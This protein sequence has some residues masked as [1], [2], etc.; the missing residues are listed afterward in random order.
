MILTGRE[1]GRALGPLSSN[2]PG[3][4]T[5]CGAK[6]AKQSLQTVPPS[7]Q[8]CS[9][10]DLSRIDTVQR[11]LSNLPYHD[12]WTGTGKDLPPGPIYFVCLLPCHTISL[13]GDFS[14]LLLSPNWIITG[15]ISPWQQCKQ[16]PSL[17]W[18]CDST[19]SF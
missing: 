10:R 16:M 7:L 4:V 11:I 6:P 8:P 9:S 19:G 3:A 15:G 13:L 12:A 1:E 14:L 18:F 5:R 17:Y 2:H